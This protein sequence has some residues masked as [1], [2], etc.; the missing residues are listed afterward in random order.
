MN[1]KWGIFLI[2]LLIS[3]KQEKKEQN[4]PDA[5]VIIT[6]NI[7]NRQVYPQ[8]HALKIIIP[9]FTNSQTIQ[10]CEIKDDNT[11]SFRIQ[12]FALRDIAI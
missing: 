7:K 9:S 5:T 12:P 8:Q 10:E 6:G 3:C 4:N 1:L 2:C 11:F